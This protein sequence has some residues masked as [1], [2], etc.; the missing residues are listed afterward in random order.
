MHG[1]FPIA[2]I[3]WIETE[4]QYTHIVQNIQFDTIRYGRLTCVLKLTRWPETEKRKNKI[5]TE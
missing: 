2:A 1:L 5:K 4:I 3:S